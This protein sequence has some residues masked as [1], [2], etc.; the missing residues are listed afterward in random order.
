MY[1]I[2]LKFKKELPKQKYLFISVLKLADDQGISDIL[3][4][5]ISICLIYYAHSSDVEVIL[6]GK[7]SDA[8]FKNVK[9]IGNH[10]KLII[11]VYNNHIMTTYESKTS[12]SM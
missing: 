1:G 9:Y 7:C 3:I 11:A 10:V 2:P 12:F 6:L 5:T 8:L 4:I